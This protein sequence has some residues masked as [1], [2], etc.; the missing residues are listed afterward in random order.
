MTTPVPAGSGK[1]LPLWARFSAD[2]RRQ[3]T[4]RASDRDREVVRDVLG[5]GYAEGRLTHVEHLERLDAVNAARTLGDLVGLVDDLVV[6]GKVSGTAVGGPLDSSAYPRWSRIL[7]TAVGGS[8]ILVAFIV[9]MVWIL[10]S[11]TQ[12]RFLYY[13]P[14]WPMFGMAIPVVAGCVIATA[15]RREK[16][17][18]TLPGRRD[19]RGELPPASTPDHD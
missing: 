12:G 11:L 10:S 14:M 6:A 8:W 3:P 4:L 16:R 18:G 7:L 2:P 19:E 13:W 15:A 5:E 9:N 17:P 1:Q